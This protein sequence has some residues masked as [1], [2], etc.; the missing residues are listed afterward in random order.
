MV[1]IPIDASYDAVVSVVNDTRHSHFPVLSKDQREVA[2]V[3]LA[4]DLLRFV[5]PETRKNLSLAAIIR[6]PAF[7]AENKPLDVLLR[8]FKATR[9]HLAIVID[10]YDAIIGLVTL[11]D[12]L[13]EIVGEIEDEYDEG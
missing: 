4:K 9:N 5:S 11:E 12:V 13:K 10:Q 7:I 2:G 6:P 3:L 8:D 1:T